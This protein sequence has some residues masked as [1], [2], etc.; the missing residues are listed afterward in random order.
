M[1]QTLAAQQKA[2]ERELELK[3]KE[4]ELSKARAELRKALVEAREAED[5]YDRD[6]ESR[7]AKAAADRSANRRYYFNTDVTRTSV[8]AARDQVLAWAAAAPG[9][10]ILFEINSNGGSVTAGLDLFGVLR[11]V[12]RNGTPVTTRATG[13]AGSMASALVQAGDVREMFAET[14]LMIHEPSNGEYGTVTEME[15]FARDMV[16]ERKALA[17]LY[18]ERSQLSEA[19]ILRRIKGRDW[20]LGAT[21][22][23]E[24][25][26]VDRVV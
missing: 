19:Q 12:S 25:G 26:L 17:A 5:K 20:L 21:E 15:N 3:E 4:L 10:P 16:L 9:E 22:A 24:L 11:S 1:A 14:W 7:Y 2:R 23:L 8:G 13:Y 18:A 6:R